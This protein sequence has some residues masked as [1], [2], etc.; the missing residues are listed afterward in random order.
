MA[1][2]SSMRLVAYKAKV[3]QERDRMEQYTCKDGT[4]F[5]RKQ[6][7][8]LF[9]ALVAGNQLEKA[10]RKLDLEMAANAI[11]ANLIEKVVT[12]DGAEH[13]AKFELKGY[14]GR[15]DVRDAREILEWLVR[16]CKV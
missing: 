7:L 2:P 16:E 12:P 8:A 1:L 5:V 9:D 15:A 11:I 10:L 14:F 13:T 3:H 4:R 6:N